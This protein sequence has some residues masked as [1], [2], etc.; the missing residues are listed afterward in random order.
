MK[1]NSKILNGCVTVQ[2]SAGDT[3]S[4]P[5]AKPRPMVSGLGDNREG[6]NNGPDSSGRVS[7][8]LADSTLPAYADS[9]NPGH[10]TETRWTTRTEKEPLQLPNGLGLPILDGNLLAQIASPDNIDKAWAN[11][12]KEMKKAPGVDRKT[13]K[14]AHDEYLKDKDAFCRRIRE[15]RWMPLPVRRVEIPKASGGW[16]PLGIPSV[17]DRVVQRAIL[18]VIEP[19][20]DRFFSEHSYGFRPKRS[21]HQAARAA[22]SIIDGGYGYVVDLDLSKYFDTVAH[23]KLMSILRGFIRDKGLLDLIWRYLR[24]GV[25]VEMIV[26]PTE[27]GVPQGGPLSPFLGNVYLHS[28]DIELEKRGLK[29]ARYADDAIIFCKSLRAAN[30]VLKSVSRFL[31]GMALK[32][33]SE[34]STVIQAQALTFLGFAFPADSIRIS[35]AKVEEFRQRITCYLKRCPDATMELHL[36]KMWRYLRGWIAHYSH[37]DDRSQLIKL[38]GWYSELVNAT[39][40]AYKGNGPDP[41]LKVL[42]A[43]PWIKLNEPPSQLHQDKSVQHSSPQSGSDKQTDFHPLAVEIKSS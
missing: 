14:E 34:K 12:R 24:A 26:Q 6:R 18:Q 41:V 16:R 30:R 8:Q 19:L 43:W 5:G 21:V 28:L 27:I 35:D 32:V 39:M 4:I 33:N 36:W 13:V 10:S 42:Y 40:A 20:V 23:D 15:G 37:L 22:R 17:F 29:F 31:S 7:G 9:G 3:G 2:S 25:M 11:V 38:K 1:N